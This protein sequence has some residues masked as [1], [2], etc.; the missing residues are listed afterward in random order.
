MRSKIEKAFLVII[1]STLCNCSIKKDENMLVVSNNQIDAEYFS[2][3]N[4]AKDPY[5]ID[6]KSLIE[7]LII[8]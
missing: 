4:K 5:F 1:F 2:Y 7:N 6:S 8:N 3:E